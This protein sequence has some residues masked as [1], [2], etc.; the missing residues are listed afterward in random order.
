MKLK[1]GLIEKIAKMTTTEKDLYLYLCRHQEPDGKVTGVYYKDV[2]A[3]CA[4]SKASYY[5]ARNGL[6]AMGAIQYEV[7]QEDCNVLVVG[8]DFSDGN[9][10]N[11]IN[12]N[13]E[14]FHRK[15][16]KKL[17]GRETYFVLEMLKNSQRDENGGVCKLKTGTLYQKYHELLNVT[18]R[19]IRSYLHVL[20]QFF[21]VGIKNGWYYIEYKKSVFDARLDKNNPNRKAED[22]W[23]IEQL[24][25][26]TYR[27][28]RRKPQNGDIANLVDIYKQFR[29]GATA[30][31]L[32]ISKLFVDA[33]KEALK[34]ANDNISFAY[35]NKLI[36]SRIMA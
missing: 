27:R 2:I 6:A 20:R 24:I 14:V 25:G 26:A 7:I 12:L 1:H 34:S 35:I 17:N 32:S 33:L 10:K 29:P 3:E 21:S 19:T 28:N 4:M 15:K 13:R 5:N 36:N 22:N 9:Y 23:Y 30:Q 11:Y 18:Y 8:N 31:G 16:F